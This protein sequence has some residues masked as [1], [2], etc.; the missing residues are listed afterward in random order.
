MTTELTKTIPW[1]SR[2]W[3]WVKKWWWLFL[4]IPLLLIAIEKFGGFIERLFTKPNKPDLMGDDKKFSDDMKN[5]TDEERKKLEAV[6]E[7]AEKIKDGIDDGSP[8]PAD[9]FDREINK[10]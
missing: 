10:P 7:E 9:I 5:L 8:T 3:R 1:T 2:V 4:I 6:D